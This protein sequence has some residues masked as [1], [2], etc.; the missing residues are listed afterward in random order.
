MSLRQ[1]YLKSI[2]PA[3]N[4]IQSPPPPTIALTLGVESTP[5]SKEGKAKRE[6]DL[7]HQ[8]FKAFSSFLLILVKGPLDCVLVVLGEMKEGAWG[9]CSM[10]GGAVLGARPF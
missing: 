3:L 2:F 10:R 6:G 5:F 4:Y 7:S 1:N 8:L 9:P